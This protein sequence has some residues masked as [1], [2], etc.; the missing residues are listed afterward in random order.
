VHA[1]GVSRRLVRL[2]DRAWQEQYE[3]ERPGATEFDTVLATWLGLH[4]ALVSSESG[5][6]PIGGRLDR[7]THLVI[8]EAQDL[9]YA[10]AQVLRGLIVPGGTLTFV[11]DLRQRLGASGGVGAWTEFQIEGLRH[12]AFRVNHRQS[13]QLGSFVAALHEELFGEAPVW[14]AAQTRQGPLPRVC[15]EADREKTASGIVREVREWRRQIRRATIGVIYDGKWPKGAVARFA[16]R[17]QELLAGDDVEVFVVGRRTRGAHLRRTDCVLVASAAATK[18]L[19]FDVVLFVDPY[20][21][22]GGKSIG[23]SPRQRNGLYVAS[24][25][26]K[27]GLSFLLPAM[28][29]A[30]ES[31]SARG[32]CV[33]V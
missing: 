20:R 33:R 22:W 7:L 6:P 13:E 3:S 31:L 23:M 18:G 1:T 4:L 9:S 11:G 28:P 32:K 19:E 24:S 27:Q 12:A 30:L 25:R 8:D 16:G 5:V 2:G 17:L 26:A 14:H 29:P 21:E 10:H 15:V